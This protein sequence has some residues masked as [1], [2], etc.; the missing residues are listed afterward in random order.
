M[1]AE[2]PTAFPKIWWMSFFL[3]L[4]VTRANRRRGI[5]SRL[6]WTAKRNKVIISDYQHD[7]ESNILLVCRSF[8]L[9]D[10]NVIFSSAK[11]WW[12]SPFSNNYAG[13]WLSGPFPVLYTNKHAVCTNQKMKRMMRGSQY[14]PGS[15]D[16]LL[17]WYVAQLP[18]LHLC[19]F[20]SPIFSSSVSVCVYSNV[21]FSWLTADVPDV[22]HQVSVWEKSVTVFLSSVILNSLFC[23]GLNYSFT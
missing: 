13:Y 14:S 1:H 8:F 19:V 4:S 20:F 23:R 3:F 6:F 10:R 11:C 5:C 22:F 18:F 16:G 2:H 17:A 15:C 12:L 21:F 9:S 7:D